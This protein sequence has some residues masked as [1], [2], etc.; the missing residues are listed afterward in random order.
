MSSS[1]R[2][3]AFDLSILVVV[4]LVLSHCL[5]G[6]AVTEIARP[7]IWSQYYFTYSKYCKGMRNIQRTKGV[8]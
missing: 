6:A 4:V 1:K 8:S 5:N 3:S 2:L 7:G